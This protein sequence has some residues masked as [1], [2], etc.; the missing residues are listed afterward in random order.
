MTRLDGLEE[1]L[2][3]LGGGLHG[4]VSRPVQRNTWAHICSVHALVK[5]LGNT[6]QLEAQM[7]LM[8]ASVTFLVLRPLG[9]GLAGAACML[10]R[11]LNWSF[12]HFH[13]S[14]Q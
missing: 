14:A 10:F 11:M 7:A 8:T 9:L 3:V 2:G 6:F 5:C 13:N 4:L 1:L 12:I